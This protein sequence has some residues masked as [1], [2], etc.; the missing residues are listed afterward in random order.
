MSYST[1][2]WSA[3]A[4]ISAMFGLMHMAL[5]FQ[6]RH[7]P[8]RLLSS[9]MALSAA[10]LAVLELM[11]ANTAGPALY[12]KLVWW[13]NLSIYGIVVPL[14][15]L[16]QQQ[17]PN[18]RRT[19]PIIVTALWTVGLLVNSV[20]PGSVTF[21]DVSELH[22]VTA[23]WGEEFSSPVGKV[24]PWKWLTDL[25]TMLVIVVAA[26]GWWY[27]RQIG[28]RATLLASCTVAFMVTGGLQ[29]AL[30][31]SGWLRMPYAISFAFLAIVA[32]FSYDLSSSEL[33]AARFARELRLQ[34]QR[35]R[36][37]LD[38]VQLA[39]LRVDAQGRI[40][41]ANPFLCRLSGYD[42]PALRGKLANDL[43][44]DW[45]ASSPISNI[46]AA[47]EPAP[48][49]RLVGHDGEFRQLLVT[50]VDMF[51]A[52]GSADG[53]VLIGDDVTDR[54]RTESRLR[55]TRREME[56]LTRAEML[57]ELSVALAHELNQPLT[58]ILSNAQAALGFL[59]VPEPELGE[60]RDILHDI[61]RDDNRAVEIIRGVRVM[62]NKGES[63][64][65]ERF[66]LNEAVR[67]ILHLLRRELEMNQVTLELQLA[68]SSVTVDGGRI[69]IQQVIMNLLMNALR[70]VQQ[71]TQTKTA[72]VLETTL[73]AE[74]VVV[75]VADRGP[76]I[77]EIDL[78]RIFE[79]FFS[80]SSGG[81]GVGLS[82]SRRIIDAHGGRLWAHARAGGG[83]R[84]SFEL[85]LATA[86]REL[87]YA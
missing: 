66:D 49:R 19:L 77:A 43:M 34:Q 54:L 22:R 50:R 74:T 5:W 57:G 8:V 81:I 71:S 26:R 41:F 30:V 83:T 53:V 9:L 6:D 62:L 32:A 63:V 27:A 75:S 80:R 18:V 16:L 55:D 86:A 7:S 56:R 84:V 15:W 17:L 1:I 4:G 39:V 20:G 29:A 68:Q 64:R 25:S 3:C 21:L 72:I 46:L 87:N 12:A 67:E 13:Q 65:R 38:K 35:W 40:A 44:P 69:E 47:D 73:G 24:N 59:D 23:F 76:G 79:P 45:H 2:A 33:R 51:A 60:I 11:L 82:I 14:V 78:K 58:A 42:N 61:V 36:T 70:A 31:D 28:S 48:V 10:T 85:P 37:L 52:D